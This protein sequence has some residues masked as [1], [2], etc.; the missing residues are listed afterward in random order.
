MLCTLK[1]SNTAWKSRL[2]ADS[3]RFA[4]G[5]LNEMF[6]V[7]MTYCTSVFPAGGSGTSIMKLHTMR[8]RGRAD[9]HRDSRYNSVRKSRNSMKHHRDRMSRHFGAKY[10]ASSGMVGATGTTALAS[11]GAGVPSAT[12]S[13]LSC[14]GVGVA[15]ALRGAKQLCCAGVSAS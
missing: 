7:P 15:A 6:R 11:S 3:R 13:W 5:R 12:V 14:G 1:H 10:G 8:S 2:R 9:S 4:G